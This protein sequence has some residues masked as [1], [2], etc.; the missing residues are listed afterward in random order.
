MPKDTLLGMF[1][2]L[3]TPTDQVLTQA[4]RQALGQ[5]HKPAPFGRPR[6]FAPAR[7]ACFFALKNAMYGL[8][9]GL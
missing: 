9:R 3:Q 7:S 6:F 4:C 5:C 8:L 2:I 1:W